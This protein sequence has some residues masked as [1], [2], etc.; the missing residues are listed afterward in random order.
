MKVLLFCIFFVL[1]S[2]AFSD[3]PDNELWRYDN[4]TSFSGIDETQF[5]DA[6]KEVSD[7]YKPIAQ[8][9]GFILNVEGDWNDSTVNAYTQRDGNEWYVAMFGG[10]AR[11]AETTKD[12][13][14]L[15]ICHEI[16]HQMGG[17]PADGWAAYEG[18]ADYIATH[19][20]GKKVFKP[21][22]MKDQI[23]VPR[24][25]LVWSKVEDQKICTRNLAAGQSLG[26]LLAALNSNPMPKYETQIGRAHV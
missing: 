18:Q 12:G 13:F 15:V 22:Q 4:K 16:A 3:L 25:C 5:N 24:A 2:Q 6:I 10:L 26:N 17:Y 9:M 7:I 23:N 20:C 14:K 19:V 21:S 8:A 1:S 11:R